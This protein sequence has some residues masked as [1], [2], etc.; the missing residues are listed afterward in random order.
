[1][2]RLSIQRPIAAAMVYLALSLL[3]VAAWRNLPIELIPN[4]EYPRL[5]VTAGWAGASPE[6]TEA[7]VTAPIEAAIQQVRG[8]ERI[9][10]RSGEGTASITVEF[11]RETDMNFARLELSERL[12]ALADDFPAGVSPPHVQPYLPESVQEQ[13]APLLS[14]TVTGPYTTEALRVQTDSLIVEP[15]QRV[16]GVAAVVVNGGRPRQL[17]IELDPTRIEGYGLTLAT[18]QQKLTA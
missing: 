6:A 16:D 13:Q 12:D 9:T 17:I 2:I 5:S 10:S 15:L 7:F 1:M 3:G 14:Y 4:T 11:Q 18:V 8:V